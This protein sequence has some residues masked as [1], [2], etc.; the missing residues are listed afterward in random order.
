MILRGDKNL[1]RTSRGGSMKRSACVVTLALMLWGGGV[2]CLACWASAA[3]D[4]CCASA[5]SIAKQ[6]AHTSQMASQQSCPKNSCCKQPKNNGSNEAF[7][8]PLDL[9]PCCL[10]NDPA[11]P[12]TL[13]Q[14]ADGGAFAA[15]IIQQPIAFEADLRRPPLTFH[16]PVLNR[17]STYLRCCV[18]LI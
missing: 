10:H 7:S 6:S 8:E 3:A 12:A 13:R 9:K 4:L 16:A 14:R 17:G 11:E 5:G 18:L 2:G 1:I 15:R